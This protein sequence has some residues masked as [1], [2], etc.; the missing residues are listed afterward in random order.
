MIGLRAVD[1]SGVVLP[2]LATHILWITLVSDGAPGLALG[3]D[4]ADAG[5][6]S[7]PPRARG[8]GAITRRMWVGIVFVGAIMAVGTLLVLDATAG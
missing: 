8:E 7:Q 5:V 6:M 2:L 3:V 4:P 1:S